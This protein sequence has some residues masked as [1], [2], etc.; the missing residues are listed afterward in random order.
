MFVFLVTSHPNIP[1]RVQEWYAP[2]KSFGA[3]LFSIVFGILAVSVTFG[4]ARKLRQ[5]VRT[6]IRS[7]LF[8]LQLLLLAWD[9]WTRCKESGQTGCLLCLSNHLWFEQKWHSRK[10]HL[11]CFA[12]E[13]DWT[14][15]RWRRAEGKKKKKESMREA[16]GDKNKKRFSKISTVKVNYLWLH[17]DFVRVGWEEKYLVWKHNA[18]WKTPR[19][20]F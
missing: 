2:Y 1:I 19:K 14:L 13:R 3:T 9:T 11:T 18:V 17:L 15:K 20:N 10:Y 7:C 8:W 4:R 5:P 12:G 6:S 16:K